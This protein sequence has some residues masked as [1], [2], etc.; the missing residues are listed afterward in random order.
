[1]MLLIGS[2]SRWARPAALTTECSNKASILR[3]GIAISRYASS[4]VRVSAIGELHFRPTSALSQDLQIL[5]SPVFRYGV[6]SAP[7]CVSA[8]IPYTK[9]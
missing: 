7:L 4:T 8:N 1:M 5:A 9:S 3:M 2:S 6:V